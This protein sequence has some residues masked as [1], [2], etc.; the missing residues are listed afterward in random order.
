[1]VPV[2][3]HTF[4][5]LC[6]A[7]VL[8]GVSLIVPA[9]AMGSRPSV[10]RPLRCVVDV[11]TLPSAGGQ[12]PRL[13]I[14]NDGPLISSGA[15]VMYRLSKGR[16]DRTGEIRLTDDIE[17]NSTSSFVVYPALGYRICTAAVR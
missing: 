7:S 12:V 14:S 13:R 2:N 8:L 17:A 16:P 9:T 1:M 4:W 15:L 3:P 6:V 11:E 5:Q 10:A